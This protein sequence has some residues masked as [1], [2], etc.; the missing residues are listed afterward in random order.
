[1]PKC[2][3]NITPYQGAGILK[4]HGNRHVNKRIDIEREH[5]LGGCLPNARIRLRIFK[6]EQGPWFIQCRFSFHTDLIC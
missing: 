3:A 6:Q 4:Q 2:N 5:I 1:M